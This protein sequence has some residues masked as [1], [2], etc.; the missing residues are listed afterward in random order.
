MNIQRHSLCRKIAAHDLNSLDEVGET[1]SGR[2]SVVPNLP[3]RL[4]WYIVDALGLDVTT[5]GNSFS[6][7]GMQDNNAVVL[8]VLSFT[9]G[10]NR[11]MLKTIW[12]RSVTM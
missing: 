7:S 9:S 6:L 11:P 8:A 10:N 4:R 1:H 5:N 2:S 3:E 12:R